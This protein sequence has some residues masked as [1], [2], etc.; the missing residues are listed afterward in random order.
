MADAMGTAFAVTA[1]GTTVAVF[2]AFLPRLE[3]VR[4]CGKDD[5]DMKGDVRLGEIAAVG[6]ALTVGF[7]LTQMSG[8]KLPLFTATLISAV[9]VGVYEYALAC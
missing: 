8:S 4:K 5:R 1:M 3:A 7:M 2:P 9:I 6:I